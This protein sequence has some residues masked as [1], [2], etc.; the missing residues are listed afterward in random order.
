MPR[1][2]ENSRVVDETRVQPN[3]AETM[4]EESTD[5][6][7]K[8]A[9]PQVLITSSHRPSLRSNLLMKELNKCIPNSSIKLRNAVTVKKIVPRAIEEGY[10]SILI[11]NEDRKMP[12]GLL[13][14]NLP[15]GPSAYFKLS[16]FRRGYD[17]RVSVRLVYSQ[18]HWKLARI[19]QIYRLE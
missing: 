2:I 12:N 11:I 19:G 9:E 14:I 16:S 7:A 5:N 13:I 3:D 4:Q 6:L 8:A 17:I 10:T 15:D 1:T 18:Q